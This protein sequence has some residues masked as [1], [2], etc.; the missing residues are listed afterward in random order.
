MPRSLSAPR[1]QATVEQVVAVAS[2]FWVL[3]ANSLFFGAALQ[4]RSLSLPGTWGFGAGL[5]VL[6]FGLHFLLLSLV[7]NRWT[8]K[9][10]VAVLLVASAAG[11]WF[12]QAYGIYLDPT[13][14]RN[15][16]RTDVAEARE[17]WSLDLLVHMALYAGLPL[18][19]LWRVHIVARPWGRAALRRG[20]ALLLAVGLLGGVLVALFQPLASLMRNHKEMRYLITPANLVWSTGAVLARDARGAAQPRQ[21]L[22]TDAVL[23]ADG[24]PRPRVLVL[25]V[26]E[27]ARAANWGLSGY[28]RQTTP[29]LARLPVLNFSQVTSCG[30]NTET[31]LPCMFA[32]VGRRDYDEGRIRGTESLLHLLARAGVDVHWRDNQSGCKG[33]CDGLPQ[34]TVAGLNPPGLCDSGRC[35]DE[36]LLAGLDQRLTRV[37]GQG[38]TH[39]WVLHM[40]GNHGPSYFRRYPPAFARFQPACE[41]DDLRTCSTEQIVNAYDNAL[42]Y[43][44]HVVGSL[45]TTLQAHAAQVDSTMIYVSDHGES[46]GEKGLYLH[47]IPYAIAPDEQ[48]RV[49]M[50]MWWSDGL[51]QREG[52]DAA[53]L[54]Q[55]AA[56]PVAHDHLFHTVLGLL[57]V[58][59]QVHEADWDLTAGCRKSPAAAQAASRP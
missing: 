29:E 52:L 39:V 33:V 40:L 10:L 58:N 30:T 11:S 6:L 34:D 20:V 5:A 43:T 46:L 8:V 7:A 24:S 27:T 45:V 15:V 22:G 50:V 28:A 3:S 13:M 54:R 12:M 56:Q 53:C 4:G 31:S 1:F 59:T 19:L 17:L 37:A 32:P 36:G 18:A 38:G 41:S 57:D 16:L 42:L 48:T 2:L 44:D 47:G 21:A 49:P 23:V 35:L 25:V 55:R 51:A 9:P 14:V 26:G